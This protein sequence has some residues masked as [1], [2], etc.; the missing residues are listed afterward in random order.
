[1]KL[2]KPVVADDSAASG[3]TAASPLIESESSQTA[4]DKSPVGGQQLEEK[5]ESGE[6]AAQVKTAAGESKAEEKFAL[7]KTEAAK[8]FTPGASVTKN[9]A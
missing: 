6:S 3:T 5:T 4:Q 1:M 2:K 9:F 8:V 7:P